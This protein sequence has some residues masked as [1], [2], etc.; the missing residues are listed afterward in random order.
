MDI[1]FW[2]ILVLSI[3]IILIG[4]TLAWFLRRSNNQQ[5]LITMGIIVMGIFGILFSIILKLRTYLFNIRGQGASIYISLIASWI[6]FLA[7][8]VL[9]F[10]MSRK[11]AAVIELKNESLA[12]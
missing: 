9:G 10:V 6:V 11:T 7:F 3:F 4:V 1:K 12:S 5:R 2:F 8:I